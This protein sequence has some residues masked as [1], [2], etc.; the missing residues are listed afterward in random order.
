MPID[1]RKK[2]PAAAVVAASPFA[3]KPLILLGAAAAPEAE[4]KE[5]EEEEDE[6]AAAAAAAADSNDKPPPCL[7]CELFGT[8]ASIIPTP[9][10]LAEE[11]KER[12]EAAEADAAREAEENRGGRLS[13]PDGGG[14]DRGTSCAA[15]VAPTALFKALRSRVSRTL[16]PGRQE[17][18]H[19]LVR[20]LLDA[21]D[22][23]R[24]EGLATTLM[25]REGEGAAPPS[26]PRRRLPPPP[27]YVSDGDAV[28]GGE[29]LSRVTCICCGGVTEAREP[30]LDLSL[31]LRATPAAA[32]AAAAEAA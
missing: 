4:K 24:R 7:H 26:L 29:L 17:D 12:I 6:D 31:P 9:K 13:R 20:T 5:E 21:V 18:A 2:R 16:T 28:F 22:R 25:A 23:D 3:P 8:L 11:A 15:A 19:E 30:F 14:G 10:A 32:V 1:P 27:R